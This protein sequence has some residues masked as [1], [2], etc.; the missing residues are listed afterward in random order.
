MTPA[1]FAV[2]L[3]ARICLVA[4]FPLSA[5]EKIFDWRAAMAQEKSSWVKVPGGPVMLVLAILVEGITPFCIVLG[6][7]DRFA[8]FVLA[9]FCVVTAFLYH[10]FWTFPHFLDPHSEAREHFW[11]FVKNFGL[12]GGLLLVVFA[13][14]LADPMQVLT[15]P[16]SS[17]YANL[18]EAAR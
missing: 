16:F 4:M 8:A 10:P 17:S 13:G 15:H 5:L 9:G 12:V 11:Q 18:S 2:L 14:T 3:V 1:T 7:H 6:W